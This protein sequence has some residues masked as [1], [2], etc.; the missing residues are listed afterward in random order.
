MVSCAT[1]SEVHGTPRLDLLGGYRYT[2]DDKLATAPPG[3]FPGSLSTSIY[4][5]GQ[6]TYL[7]DV[8]Y[9]PTE[10]ETTFLPL[11]GVTPQAGV[12][13]VDFNYTGVSPLLPA[14]APRRS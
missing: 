9:K 10:F 3:I 14:P 5:K 8:N 12:G 7:A 13:H 11:T 2:Q 6:S 4:S 1:T